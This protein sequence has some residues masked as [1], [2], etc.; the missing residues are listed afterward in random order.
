MVKPITLFSSAAGLNTKHDP[1]RLLAGT[2]D[3]PGL[4][5][6]S[7]A[8]NV[9]IDDRGLVE[10]RPGST[11]LHSGIFHSL[12]R[13]DGECFVVQENTTDAAIMQV[14]ADYSLSV[15]KTG[16]TKNLRM[17]WMQVNDSVFCSN[18]AQRGIINNGIWYDW[19]TPAAWSGPDSSEVFSP[20]PNSLHMAHRSGVVGLACGNTVCFNRV[21]FNYFLFNLT[22]DA[23]TFPS[24]VLMVA[25]VD[26]GFYVSDEHAVWFFRGDHPRNFTQIKADEHPAVEWSLAHNPLDL[27][28]IMDIQGYAAVWINKDGIR[29]GMPDGK[30]MPF[31]EDKAPLP[32]SVSGQSGATLVT[33]SKIIA[34]L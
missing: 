9:A 21:P 33:R 19:P 29:V 15:V 26:G 27:S 3:D 13:D 23:I 4:I 11:S 5:E 18:G 17:A 6:F 16:L 28:D 10:L 20:A 22:D 25:A 7:Q 8:V 34:A 32:A 12:F 24:K 1:Q 30:T 14:A 2:K 31:T